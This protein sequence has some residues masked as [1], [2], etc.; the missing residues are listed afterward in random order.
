MDRYFSRRQLVG[1]A[2]MATAA[3][4]TFEAAGAAAIRPS[5]RT[6]I[7]YIHSHDSGRYL[8]PYG[9]AVP[10]PRLAGLAR[11]GVLFRQM[12]CASPSCSASRA[13]MLT[14]QSA[15]SSGMLG[16]AHR[17]WSLAHPERHIVHTLGRAGYHTVLAGLQHVAR[18]ANA[19]GYA[20]ILP[21]RSNLV[22]DV[23]PGAAA[24]LRSPAAKAQP[25][26]LDVGFQETHR[27]FPAPVDDPS[28]VQPPLPIADTQ[29]GRRDMAGY[30]ASARQLDQGVGQILDALHAAGLAE[31]TLVI[32]T[33]D[34][35]LPFP[36]MKGELR[37]G[38]T[39]VSMM[40]RGPGAF[41]RAQSCDALLSHV[42]LFPTLCDY[43]GIDPP[44]WL[45]GRSFLPVVDGRV[46]EINE[47]IYTELNFHAAY[48]P[49]R[50]VRT[51][52]YKY[53]R[54]FDDRHLPV[55]VN[56]DDGP[57]KAEWIRHGWKDHP[58][59][60]DANG[61]EL[62]DLFFDP[63]EQINLAAVTEHRQTLD[64]M[65]VRLQGWMQETRDPLAKGPIVPPPTVRSDDPDTRSPGKGTTRAT[66]H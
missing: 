1:A 8:S 31:D 56:S 15:H 12:H 26:F 13:A 52:R 48:E 65:R 62:F 4:L 33:T 54:R 25:F 3:P 16:L 63:L 2:A 30:H 19:I 41:A 5:R 51:T 28:Y 32:S 59:I 39:G 9:H 47:A 66:T 38:G 18:D 61:E 21:H 36:T 27:P 44:D 53:I 40:M 43:V 23:A 6:N 55:L 60:A 46:K 7:V 17:G 11:E 42:D 37:D 20:Q 14:G 45:E 64:E 35:G 50:A 34:H 57:S 22:R 24:F 10:T 58:L 49:K 29:E